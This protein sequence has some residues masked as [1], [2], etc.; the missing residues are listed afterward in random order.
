MVVLINSET[1][2]LVNEGDVVI[3]NHP[4]DIP[5]MEGLK[6]IY[7][8]WMPPHRQN[9]HGLMFVRFPHKE[10]DDSYLPPNYGY[11]LVEL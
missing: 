1:G 6:G 11:K 9:E 8:G 10:W 3:T 4:D 5:I 7:T 2:E